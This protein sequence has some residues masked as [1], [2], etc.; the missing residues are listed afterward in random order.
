MNQNGPLGDINRCVM[1]Q[2]GL[3]FAT[4]LLSAVQEGLKRGTVEVKLLLL[5]IFRLLTPL[6]KP[7]WTRP[8]GRKTAVAKFIVL[9]WGIESTMA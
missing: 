3:D 6:T 8:L 2:Y 1:L 4:A 9:Y 5:S 7:F